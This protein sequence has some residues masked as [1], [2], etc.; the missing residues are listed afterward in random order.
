ML[1]LDSS[2]R[3]VSVCPRRGSGQSVYTIFQRVGILHSLSSAACLGGDLESSATA[4]SADITNRHVA[5]DYGVGVY[6]HA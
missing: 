4:Q 2:A 1:R 3:S 6:G 5:Q